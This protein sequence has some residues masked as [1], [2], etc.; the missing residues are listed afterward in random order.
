MKMDMEKIRSNIDRHRDLWQSVVLNLVLALLGQISAA[1]RGITLN[2]DGE[3]IQVVVYFER[4]PTESEVED[5]ECVEAELVSHHDYLSELTLVVVPPTDTL[6]DKVKN[7]GWV[8]LRRE[9]A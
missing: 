4:T 5:L 1:V 2:F 7:W 8:F 9:I 3:T 6:V